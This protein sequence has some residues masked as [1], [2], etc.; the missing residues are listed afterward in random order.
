MNFNFIRWVS[1]AN[2][3]QTNDRRRGGG[4][5]NVCDV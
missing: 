5:R 2:C 1:L 3:K 4:K